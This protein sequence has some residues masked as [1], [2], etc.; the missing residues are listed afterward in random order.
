MVQ[1]FGGETIYLTVRNI[2]RQ[3]LDPLYVYF[4]SRSFT[5]IAGN[6]TQ[7]GQAN[8]S[9]TAPNVSLGLNATIVVSWVN[10][11]HLNFSLFATGGK[12]YYYDPPTITVNGLMSTS[13]GTLNFSLTSPGLIDSSTLPAFILVNNA[14]CTGISRTVL[15]IFCNAPAGIG[16]NVPVSVIWPSTI[17]EVL[18]TATASYIAASV[19]GFIANSAING[20]VSLSNYI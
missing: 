4:K 9:F 18:S 20:S 2:G 5:T 1:V 15:N 3:N 8:I 19:D 10:S 14:N 11:S 6:I 12:S 17:Y 16:L 7:W 13:N